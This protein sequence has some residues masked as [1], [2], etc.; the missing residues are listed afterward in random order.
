LYQV[1]GCSVA[2]VLQRMDK[3]RNPPLYL[4]GLKK[5]SYAEEVGG[6]AGDSADRHHVVQL[7]L[8]AW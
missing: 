3:R 2:D 6:F 1:K 7:A 4:T 8:G 5:A